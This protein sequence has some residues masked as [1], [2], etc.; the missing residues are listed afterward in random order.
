MAV[1]TAKTN[2]RIRESGGDRIFLIAVYTLLTLVLLAVLYPLIYV[3]SSSLSSPLA[4]SSGLVKLWPVDV[5]LRG[6]QV[7]LENPQIV[8]GYVNSLFYSVAGA[9]ISLTLTIAIA[10]PLSRKSF[11]GRNVIM[12]FIVITMLFSG[13][14]IPTYLVVR[15]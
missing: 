5:T 7:A 10:Y 3:L 9:L 2:T 4:V 1:I 15:D 6:Y 8:T 11:F 12:L 13:G 14:L